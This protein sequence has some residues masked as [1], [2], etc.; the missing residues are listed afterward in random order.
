M[1]LHGTVGRLPGTWVA[2]ADSFVDDAEPLVTW[3][4]GLAGCPALLA[5]ESALVPA[6]ELERSSPRY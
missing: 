4:V 1:S 3:A 6:S 5:A 2:P